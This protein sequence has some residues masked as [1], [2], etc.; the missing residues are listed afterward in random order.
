M[1]KLN[2]VCDTILSGFVFVEC[3]L[4][5][6]LSDSFLRPT[7][8]EESVVTIMNN[9]NSTLTV[10]DYLV[11]FEVIAYLSILPLLLHFHNE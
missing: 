6:K 11:Y 10:L 2:S 8:R 7:F 4:S 3:V 9:G 5:E 1:T